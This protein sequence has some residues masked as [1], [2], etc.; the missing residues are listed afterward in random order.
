M[1]AHECLLQT[2]RAYICGTLAPNQREEA[3]AVLLAARTTKERAERFYAGVRYPGNRDAAGRELYPLF[4]IPPYNQGKKLKTLLDQTPKTHLFS[5]NS[6]ELEILRLLHLFLPENKEVRHMVTQTLRRLQ[7][8]CFGFQDDGV[9][10]CFETSLVVLRFIG[11]VAP[12]E[13]TWIKSRIINYLAHAADKKRASFSQW[14]FWLCLSEMPF[15]IAKGEAEPYLPEIKNWLFHKSCV[16]HSPHDHT[17]HPVLLCLLRNLLAKYP[18]Y[19]NILHCQPV[20]SEK[21]GRLR[22]D[23]A[24]EN[25]LIKKTDV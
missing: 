21:D 18:G 22:L 16:M 15:E 23:I 9:G 10:E 19:E 5:A 11:T 3:A 1:T 8:T 17:V 2:D 20:V 6:Y 7:T 24:R 25:V 4:F 12:R 14:Y 13:E